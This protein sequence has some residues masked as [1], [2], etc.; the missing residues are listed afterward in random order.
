MP[1]ASWDLVRVRGPS[2]TRS[3]SLPVDSQLLGLDPW[4]IWIMDP[5]LGG[6]FDAIK[7]N[8]HTRRTGHVTM[9][10]NSIVV[11]FRFAYL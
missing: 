6:Q 8:S 7:L 3:T 10:E 5:L 2:N 11:W 9:R 4:C 1:C